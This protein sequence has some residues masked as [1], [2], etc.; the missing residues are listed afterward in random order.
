MTTVL[1]EPDLGRVSGGL[2]FNAEL[3]AASAGR[4]ERVR[5]PGA[6]PEPSPDE[7]RVLFDMVERCRRGDNASGSRVVLVDSLI[8]CSLPMPLPG[9]VVI[10]HHSFIAQTA[11]SAEPCGSDSASQR[12]QRCLSAASAVIVP[13]LFAAAALAERYGIRARV[14]NPG[15][16]P[17]PVANSSGPAHLICVAAVETNKNQ[18]FLA[19]V[20]GELSRRGLTDWRCTLA[21]PVT[22]PDYC[23]EVSSVVAGIGRVDVVGERDVTGIDAL[24]G[25]ADL[26]LLPSRTETFGMVVREAAAAAVP[27]LVTRGTGAEEALISGWAMPL[28]LGLW[29]DE[30]ER[31]LTD[32]RFRDGLHEEAL[33]RRRSIPG[34]DK[35]ARTVLSI[36]AAL[37]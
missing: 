19:R 5:V 33:L 21:G 16:R 35:S 34:W 26:L 13:S 6:W 32:A 1:V 37:P 11:D 14:A 2:R 24:Y 3:A 17:R 28:D 8:A 25:Q 7:V 12:E 36:V 31:W 22:D 18:L 10:L 9:P 29:A 30:L 4:I 27:A 20:L 15:T 23:R